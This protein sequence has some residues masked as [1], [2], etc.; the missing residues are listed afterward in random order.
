LRLT[1]TNIERDWVLTLWGRNLLNEEYYAMGLDI[2][3]MGGYAG[4]TAPD[5]TYGV[6]LRYTF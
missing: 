2:P 1:L 5:A 4:V 3:V 6:T